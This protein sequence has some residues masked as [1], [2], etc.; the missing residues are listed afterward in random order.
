MAST[1]VSGLP[2]GSI[3]MHGTSEFCVLIAS[4]R[5]LNASRQAFIQMKMRITFFIVF[6]SEI[7]IY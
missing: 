1:E 5:L 7:F 4:I 6:L 3:G 2:H